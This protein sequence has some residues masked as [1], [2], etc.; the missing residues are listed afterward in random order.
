[1]KIRKLLSLVLTIV[2][3]CSCMNAITTTVSASSSISELQAKYP[4]GSK[5]Y[6]S[7]DGSKQCAGFARMLAFEAY[8][9]EYYIYNNDG[10]WK[11]VTDSSYIDNN[12]KSGDYVRYRYNGHSIWV[13]KVDGDTVYIADCNADG[14]CT[15]RWRTVTKAD[16]KKGFTHVYSAP[17][18]LDNSANH[19]QLYETAIVT[20]KTGLTIRQQ[21]DINSSKVGYLASGAYVNVCHNPVKDS[22]GYYWRL[23]LDGRGWICSSYINATSGQCYVSGTYKIQSS[24]GKFLSY[25]STPAKG[26]NIVMYEDLSNTEIADWQLWNFTPLFYYHDSG[27]VVYRIT[28]VLNS[29]YSLDCDSTQNEVLHLYDTLD[30][31]AQKWIVE[32]RSDGSLRILNDATRYVLDIQNASNENNAEVITYPS[33]NGSNQQFFLVE[34]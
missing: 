25:T 20:A 26:V 17:Y 10:K 13:Y 22:S 21:P 24:N 32:V 27:A 1:M 2:M 23:L 16:L 5:W 4:D 6:D 34:P 18:A 11:K 8:D 19:V 31:S 9:S 15:V 33:H 3:L 7:F 29:Q 30:I 28:P 14:N 12:L